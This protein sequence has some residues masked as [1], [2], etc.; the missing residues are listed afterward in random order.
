MNPALLITL[1]I[2]SFAC[3]FIGAVS[4]RHALRHSRGTITI[5][6]D[7]L[8]V[9][10]AAPSYMGRAGIV[11]TIRSLAD[12]L[13]SQPPPPDT[14]AAKADKHLRSSKAKKPRKVRVKKARFPEVR[15]AFSWSS[16][17][18]NR[19]SGRPLDRSFPSLPAAVENFSNRDLS[20][21]SFAQKVL[22]GANFRDAE[23]DGANFTRAD[24]RRAN[25]QY[26]N[27][28][29]ATLRSANLSYANLNDANLLRADLRAAALFKADLR[30]ANLAG[31][32][33]RNADLRDAEFYISDLGGSKWDDT[34]RWSPEVMKTLRK[35]SRKISSSTYEVGP[36]PEEI[37]SGVKLR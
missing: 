16:R 23:L 12:E 37:G 9:T 22:I 15:K 8:D 31:A 29:G 4:G 13:E 14:R 25:L 18:L 26:A 2:G 27:F 32:D 30:G 33:L 5:V 3:T 35:S 36:N 21:A 20:K 11:S 19:V 28:A 17:S 7:G 10:I 24:L 1:V 34:T 6:E